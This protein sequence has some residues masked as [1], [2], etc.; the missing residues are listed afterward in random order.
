MIHSIFFQLKENFTTHTR[1]KGFITTGLIKTMELKI[2]VY[3]L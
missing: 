2:G 1:K 3:P